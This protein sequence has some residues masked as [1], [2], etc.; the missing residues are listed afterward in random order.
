MKLSRINSYAVI[1]LALIGLA[2]CL[3]NGSS[4]HGESAALANNSVVVANNKV[5]IY[6]TANEKIDQLRQKGIKVRD[7]GS[8]WL[9][10]AT[11]AQV[12]ELTKI[13]G[14]RA[15]KESR[16]NRIQLGVVSFDTT[17]G[18]PVIPAGFRQK[19]EGLGK[20]LRLVQ[21]RGPIM[22]EWLRL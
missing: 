8:Y 1:S 5:V 14:A 4:S 3:H 12:A 20:R 7:Y 9:A 17:A 10:E 2:G 19:E 15:S 21:F 18:E 13:Y 22:P 11:D 16:F 6:P